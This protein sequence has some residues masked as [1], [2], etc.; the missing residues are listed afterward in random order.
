MR[1]DRLI[2]AL[3]TAIALLIVGAPARAQTP[4]P[5]RPIECIIPFAPGGPT[6]TA[7]RL[8]QPQLST[9]LGVPLVLVNKAGGGGALGMDA[10][11]KAKPDGYTL[12]APSA[13]PSLSC[14][15][16]NRT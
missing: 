3:A 12:A 11:A 15:R 16:P 8:I 14:L 6:D 7:I 1:P 10:V 5:A 4:Y 9:N 2:A 13:P